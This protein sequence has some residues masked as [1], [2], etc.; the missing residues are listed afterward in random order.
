MTAAQTERPG[1]VD[2]CPYCRS[3]VN[4]QP[5]FAWWWHFGGVSA[6]QS[7]SCCAAEEHLKRQSRGQQTSAPINLGGPAPAGAP[8]PRAPA[9][10][11]IPIAGAPQ[12]PAAPPAGAPPPRIAT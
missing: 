4:P 8:P 10:G 5:L 7:P 1:D 2:V 11:P 9:S 6:G 12:P 3:I